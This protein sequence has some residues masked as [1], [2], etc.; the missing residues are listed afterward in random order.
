MTFGPHQAD[1]YELELL[2]R[3]RAI[4]NGKIH[5]RSCANL[6]DGAEDLR[7]V[8]AGEHFLVYLERPYEIVIVDILHSRSDLPRHVAVLAALKQQ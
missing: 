1:A 6:V 7:Y 2:G 5:G 4:V 8:R 3:C